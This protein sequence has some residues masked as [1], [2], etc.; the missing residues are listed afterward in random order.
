MIGG[1]SMVAYADSCNRVSAAAANRKY[2]QNVF[3]ECAE[4][5]RTDWEQTHSS[6]A[7]R[8]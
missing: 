2:G 5:A 7:Q 8:E 4:Q 1:A 3:A 6:Q